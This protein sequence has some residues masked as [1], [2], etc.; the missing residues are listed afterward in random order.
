[1][2][3]ARKGDAA[4]ARRILQG[5]VDSKASAEVVAEASREL[6]KIAK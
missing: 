1:V 4:E 2:A 6:A 3:L 5:V